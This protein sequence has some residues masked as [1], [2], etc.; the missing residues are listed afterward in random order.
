MAGCTPGWSSAGARTALERRLAA[1]ELSTPA[2]R[3]GGPGCAVP[4]L[5]GPCGRPGQRLPG[6]SR[7][8]AWSHPGSRSA[9]RRSAG[10]R[11]RPR[12]SL[13]AV[14]RH[15]RWAEGVAWGTSPLRCS[16]PASM[17]SRGFARCPPAAWARG[18]FSDHLQVGVL[19]RV[20][21][22]G[23]P[24]AAAKSQRPDDLVCRVQRRRPGTHFAWGREL[25]HCCV[26]V[27]ESR[28]WGTDLLWLSCASSDLFCSGCGRSQVQEPD[29]GSASYTFV[30]WCQALLPWPREV[31]RTCARRP[32]GEWCARGV[33][34][35]SLL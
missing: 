32:A 16:D 29:V 25:C 3:G 8:R 5:S 6:C 34:V 19:V 26:A 1:L 4:L 17:G 20:L 13:R 35:L 24:A 14:P 10:R 15:C 9:P 21:R 18:G 27:P 28:G 30:G 12:D 23:V 2:V 22:G 7:C 11:A 31:P 33:P